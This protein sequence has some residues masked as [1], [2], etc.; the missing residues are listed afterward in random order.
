MKK[1]MK[2][3]LIGL[4]S[5]PLLV[6]TLFTLTA[7]KSEIKSI[8]GL[9]DLATSTIESVE[10]STEFKNS[11]TTNFYE[12][13]SETG[14]YTVISIDSYI[15]SYTKNGDPFFDIKVAL[16]VA[17][18]NID[19]NYAKTRLIYD[20][21][22]AYS[23]NVIKDN[24]E[25]LN[26]IRDVKLNSSTK[27]AA[28]NLTSYLN[29]FNYKLNQQKLNRNEFVDYIYDLNTQ[30][31]NDK[32]AENAL[33]NYI[34]DYKSVV[35]DGLELAKVSTAVL[36]TFMGN[37]SAVEYKPETTTP[38][39][40]EESETEV[41]KKRY[42]NKFAL[43]I[44]DTYFK[45]LAESTGFSQSNTTSDF[46]KMC[47]QVYDEYL[48]FCGKIFKGL[49][50]E[51]NYTETLSE[52]D[53]VKLEKEKV[54]L[55]VEETNIDNLFESFNIQNINIY[56]DGDETKFSSKEKTQFNYLSIYYLEIVKD[57]WTTFTEKI[58]K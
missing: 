2:K 50:S 23:Y 13:N 34:K 35:R 7:C 54:A 29:S 12:N 1:I 30:G 28:E 56:K 31:W 22:W 19:S 21:T 4:L 27:K 58:F 41:L 33:Y 44:F 39:D 15:P 16:E 11:S 6:G 38:D 32:L 49:S 43:Q 48:Q 5:I 25:V 3:S 17:T 36:D 9:C 37:E 45:F 40:G 24:I 51:E 20:T 26:S 55:D 46:G 18:Q 8:E 47:K 10:T 57:W 53:F 42:S 52:V 14:L